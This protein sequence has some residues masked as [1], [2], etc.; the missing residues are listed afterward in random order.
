MDQSS[1][2][3]ADD[4]RNKSMQNK[5]IH[6][7][8]RLEEERDLSNTSVLQ[9]WSNFS[10]PRGRGHSGFL[11]TGILVREVDKKPKNIKKLS[12]IQKYQQIIKKSFS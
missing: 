7:G 9:L 8:G 11:D 5:A 10:T 2:C 6:L 3:Y 4:I 12:E 1:C